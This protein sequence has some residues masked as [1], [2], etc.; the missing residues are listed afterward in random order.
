MSQAS[1]PPGAVADARCFG[2]SSTLENWVREFEKFTTDISVVTYYGSMEERLELRRT[3]PGRAEDGELDVVLTTYDMAWKHDDQ[4]FLRK[5]MSFVVSR[6]KQQGGRSADTL[7]SP[8]S[9]TRATCSRTSS[10]S[11]TRA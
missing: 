6:G 5:K 2:S 10:V 11:A 9:L 1:R 3:F 4:R 8:A 7:L